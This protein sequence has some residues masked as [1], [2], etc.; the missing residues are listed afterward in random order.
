[1][2]AS[3]L[4]ALLA[5]AS[6]SQRGLAMLLEVNERTVRCYALGQMPIRRTT[7]YAIRWA[8]KLESEQREASGTAP[9]PQTLAGAARQA[10]PPPGTWK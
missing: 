1:M 4:R 10:G 8:L 2:T 6:V 9:N 7:E 5:T 3:E